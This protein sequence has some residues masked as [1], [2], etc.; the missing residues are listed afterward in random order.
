[1]S[2]T[3]YYYTDTSGRS[4]LEFQSWTPTSASV[5]C[6]GDYQGTQISQ[7]LTW[8]AGQHRFNGSGGFYIEPPPTFALVGTYTG[9]GSNPEESVRIL[10]D[11]EL[12]TL[13]PQ[14]SWDLAGTDYE[15]GSFDLASGGIFDPIGD[16]ASYFHAFQFV[17]VKM[18]VRER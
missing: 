15:V 18:E 17:P 1:M 7:P 8:S 4:D 16:S 3:H 9:A 14:T 5:L 13:T 10:T 2:V 12:K 6:Y 11:D